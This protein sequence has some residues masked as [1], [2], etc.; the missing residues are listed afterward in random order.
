MKQVCSAEA[1]FDAQVQSAR[2]QKPGNRAILRDDV[3]RGRVSGELPP[4]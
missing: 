2:G 4:R 3:Q 1:S